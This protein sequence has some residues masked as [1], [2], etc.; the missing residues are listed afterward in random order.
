MH[1]GEAIPRMDA[2]AEPKASA[3]TANSES[4]A[5]MA[6]LKQPPQPRR[7]SYIMLAN[8]TILVLVLVAS[9][10][11]PLKDVLFAVFASAYFVAMG[12]FVY[13]SPT[14]ER[15]PSVFPKNRL[16]GYYVGVAGIIAIPFPAAYIL[17]S[18]VKGDQVA[19]TSAAPHLF[20][21]VCQVL[22]E[23]TVASMVTAVSLPV[24]ALVPILYNSRRLVT[25]SAWLE[26]EFARAPSDSA[27]F[28]WIM[29]GRGLA[30]VNMAVWTFNLLGF[31][32]PVYLPLVM[33]MHYDLERLSKEH[34]S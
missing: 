34:R 1:S 29:F 20:L 11:V 7:P 30:T 19:M 8:M 27:S 32:L 25:L 3:I 21:L 31:L 6:Q 16:L 10:L 15:P 9:G 2:R 12:K 5:A 33:R 14:K 28:Q 18:F 23:M 24:R 4:Q 22:T 26:F 13:P 17:G